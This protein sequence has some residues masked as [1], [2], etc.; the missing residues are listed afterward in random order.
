MRYSTAQELFCTAF[1]PMKSKLSQCFGFKVR[2]F[3]ALRR[4]NYW[5]SIRMLTRRFDSVTRIIA[6][7][8]RL[9]PTPSCISRS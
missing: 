1:L 5:I 9:L 3:V 8:K 2:T 6:L 4:R 7:R